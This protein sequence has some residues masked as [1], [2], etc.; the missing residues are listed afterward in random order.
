M[1]LLDCEDPCGILFV[2]LRNCISPLSLYSQSRAKLLAISLCEIMTTV[3]TTILTGR[4]KEWCNKCTDKVIGVGGRQIIYR[5][6][7]SGKDSMW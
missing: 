7:I 6:K 5:I 3:Q 2:L 4:I 1:F